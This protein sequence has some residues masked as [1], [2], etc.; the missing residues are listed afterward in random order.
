MV[1]YCCNNFH[2]LKITFANE[3]ARL[4]EALGVD[5]FEVM[6]LVCKDRQLNISPAY[7]KPG[8]AFGGSCL[9]KDL[10]ATLHL[11]K[12]RDVELPMLGGDPGVEPRAHRARDRQGAGDRQAPDR[13]DRAVVQDRHRRPA[14]EP[15][16]PA[17]RASSSARDCRCSSTIRRCTCRSLLGANRRFIEQHLPH[18]GSL[19]RGDVDRVVAD[20]E[21]LIVGMSDPVLFDRV[22]GKVRADQVVVDLANVP[23]PREWP[24]VVEGLC[25]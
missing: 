8:F 23:S 21:V 4:C 10:R 22:R 17:R 6:D 7:L 24:C 9:P 13:H 1:K 5:P 3:T 15:A 11:A 20:S 25:W 2:A 19:I 16:G 18:I 12:M 14:R